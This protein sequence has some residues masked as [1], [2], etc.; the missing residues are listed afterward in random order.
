MSI[1]PP[2]A[3]VFLLA[4]CVAAFAYSKPAAALNLGIAA[5]AATSGWDQAIDEGI[6]E[7][8][9]NQELAQER[10]MARLQSGIPQLT[11]MRMLERNS[12]QIFASLVHILK[13]AA[14]PN[15]PS[16]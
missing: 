11:R 6:A 7:R 3:K 15:T 9:A 14:R 1:F 4:V 2:T 5:G 12:D 16:P 8:E 10:Q 13:Q